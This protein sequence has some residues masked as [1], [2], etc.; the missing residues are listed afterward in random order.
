MPKKPRNS[1]ASRRGFLRTLLMD[2]PPKSKEER[3][4]ERKRSQRASILALKYA[5]SEA[6]LTKIGVESPQPID[7][8]VFRVKISGTRADNQTCMLELQVDTSSDMVGQFQS[9]SQPPE[10]SPPS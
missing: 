7:E 5:K 9:E 8:Y 4:E 3:E 10:E 1:Q 2:L 6:Y